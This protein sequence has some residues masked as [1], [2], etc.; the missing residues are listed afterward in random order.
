MCRVSGLGCCGQSAKGF[1]LM[2][3][4]VEGFKGLSTVYILGQWNVHVMVL[5]P[6]TI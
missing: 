5:Y 2:G 3:F 6:P 4:R 1:G